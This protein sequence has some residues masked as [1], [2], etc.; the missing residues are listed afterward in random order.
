[1]QITATPP[2]GANRLPIS[3]PNN[4]YKGL[5]YYTPVDTG[6]FGARDRDVQLCA[7]LVAEEDLKVLLLH[8]TTGCG[9]SSFLRA[10]LIPYLESTVGGFQF[11]RTF[12]S[13]VSTHE[14]N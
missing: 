3:W 11:L 4:P 13:P 1:M 8:G 10:G 9:K 5:S 2:P 7:Q 12:V 6:L 14:T